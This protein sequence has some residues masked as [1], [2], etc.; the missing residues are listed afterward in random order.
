MLISDILHTKGHHVTTAQ[1][2]D[3]VITTV[4]ALAEKRIGAV[5]VEDPLQKVVG[6]FSERDLVN[7]LA[8]Y[9]PSALDREVRGLM[10]SPIVSCLPSERVDVA[11]ATMTRRRIRHLPVIEN[12]H[13]I[14]IVSIGDLVHGRLDEKELE[15][16]VLL[17]ITRLRA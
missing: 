15:A 4:K 1:T 12:G 3:L 2:S 8:H 17:D 11:L 7:A 16:G 10:S 9:G 5:V 13:L 6:I 14:G